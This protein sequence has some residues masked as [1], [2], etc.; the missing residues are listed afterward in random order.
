MRE[1]L[2]KQRVKLQKAYNDYK[3][4]LEV[5]KTLEAIIKDIE[6]KTEED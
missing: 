3:V 1:A 6:K 4:E 2:D 5:Y